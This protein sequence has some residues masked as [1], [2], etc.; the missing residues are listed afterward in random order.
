L[1]LHH[2]VRAWREIE[3]FLGK[4]FREAGED[5]AQPYK[6]EDVPVSDN[7][8]RPV[9]VLLERCQ[10]FRQRPLDLDRAG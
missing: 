1:F 2:L 3:Q 7:G 4:R 8:K 10:G 5:I 6:S 9:T